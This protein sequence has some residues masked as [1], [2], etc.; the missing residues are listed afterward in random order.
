MIDPRRSL[1]HLCV[2]ASLRLIPAL[3]CLLPTLQA[4]DH[5][6]ISNRRYANVMGVQGADW[7]VRPE[8]ETE[9][10]PDKTLDLIGIAKSS[11]VAD[12]GAGNGYITWRMAERVGPTGKVYA[13]DIQQEMLDQLRRNITDRKLT[14]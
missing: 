8:R 11:T 3:L 4:Q 10:A 14:N 5:H 12:L 6:P 7:L 2:S 9:E 1:S 13:V